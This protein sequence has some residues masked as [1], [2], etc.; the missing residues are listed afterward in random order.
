MSKS[1][2]MAEFKSAV[3]ALA[4]PMFNIVYA[5]RDGNIFYLYNGAVAKRD[6]KYDW[7][8]PMDGS[9]PGTEWQGFLTMDQLPQATNP[10]SGFVQNCNQ[11]P[12]LD[13]KSTRLNS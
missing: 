3:S 7:S 9:D 11:S 5:D 1:K 6:T 2:N 12:Y 13:R 4:I 8:K 10:K